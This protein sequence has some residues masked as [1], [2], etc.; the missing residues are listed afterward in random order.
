MEVHGTSGVPVVLLP[1]GA[2][3]CDGFFPGLVEGLVADPGCR[4]V[5]HDRPGTGAAGPGQL[6][7]ATAHLHALVA[8]L[9]LGPVVVV[10]QS[11]GGAVAS[12]WARDHPD[13]LAG[14][15]LLDATPINDPRTCRLIEGQMRAV[16]VPARIPGL[17][18]LLD[19]GFQWLGRRQV[20]RTPLPPEGVAAL[21][22]TMAG[23]IAQL[24]AATRGLVALADGFRD[25]DLP[26]LPSAVV[27]A[28][29]AKPGAMGRSHERLAT[30]FGAPVTTWPGAAHTVHLDHPA[31]VLAVVRDVVGRVSPTRPV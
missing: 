9:G 17:G 23:D 11:L 15:V 5:V 4:V 12:L 14:I 27:T 29:R 22:V 16:A 28:D 10:G 19:K 6:K 18:P 7:D 13:D 8:D 1:G 31:E 20:L 3:P 2:A 30:A 21:E 24:A 26:L 25:T